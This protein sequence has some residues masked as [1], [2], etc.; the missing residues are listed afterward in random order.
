MSQAEERNRMETQRT[1]LAHFICEQAVYFERDCLDADKIKSKAISA[2]WQR[3]VDDV[4]DKNF[5]DIDIYA[6][7]H[8]CYLMELLYTRR[9]DKEWDKFRGKDAKTLF[10]T[11]LSIAIAFTE[12]KRSD[13]RHRFLAM[14]S[15]NESSWKA[16]FGNWPACQYALQLKKDMAAYKLEKEEVK[17]ETAYL[18]HMEGL[19]LDY[20][21][22]DI[23]MPDDTYDRLKYDILC[24]GV[25]RQHVAD[26]A[27]FSFTEN[28]QMDKILKEMEEKTSSNYTVNDIY[29]VRY[30][31]MTD[32]C[33]F[34]V[35]Q[36]FHPMDF[37]C[38]EKPILVS[39]VTY[40]I[41]PSPSSASSQSV[42]P[43]PAPSS[44][45]IYTSPSSPSSPVQLPSASEIKAICSD[46]MDL[47]CHEEDPLRYLNNTSPPQIND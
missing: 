37:T 12:D 1:C 24:S 34:A 11:V 38:Q 2:R 31:G 19:L 33:A 36:A 44:P 8:A 6:L 43:P 45:S 32:S 18:T 20:L 35:R 25:I 14:V 13:K 41:P 5:M 7:I 39:S 3:I 22:F 40:H 23:A 30:L 15:R 21:H 16:F 4:L 26:R 10:Y 27:L 9:N 47:V 17:K 42:T 29:K 28:I 46:D